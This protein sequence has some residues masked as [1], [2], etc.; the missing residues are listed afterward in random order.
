MALK[1]LVNEPVASKPSRLERWSEI[2]HARKCKHLLEILSERL[3]AKLLHES[4]KRGL[5]R[6]D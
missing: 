5:I 3:L 2:A 1:Q 6:E 4:L